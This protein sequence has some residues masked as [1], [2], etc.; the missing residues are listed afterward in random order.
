MYIKY[1]K[2]LKYLSMNIWIYKNLTESIWTK[3]QIWSQGVLKKWGNS[4]EY[5]VFHGQ[6]RENKWIGR[7]Q[8][9]KM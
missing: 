5:E 3:L 1:Y 8:K 2:Y 6:A 9:K 7:R 4:K